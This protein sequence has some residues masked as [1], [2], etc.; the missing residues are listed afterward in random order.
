[1]TKTPLT[2][3][4]SERPQLLGE[5]LRAVSG[6]TVR[7]RDT[8]AFRGEPTGDGAADASARPGDQRPL[9]VE[10]HGYAARRR[11]RCAGRTTRSPS[12][13]NRSKGA[14]ASWIRSTSTNSII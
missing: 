7:Q 14:S 1:M 13:Q 4:G 2:Y 8:S 9:S 10:E 11:S 3:G 5:R 6:A 12:S